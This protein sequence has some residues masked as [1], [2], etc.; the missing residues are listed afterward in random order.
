MR[1]ATTITNTTVPAD[2]TCT[3]AIAMTTNQG[4]QGHTHNQQRRK[5]QQQQQQPLRQ[6][7]TRAPAITATSLIC[8]SCSALHD[9]LRSAP[10]P[11]RSTAE[12]QGTRT[13]SRESRA[14]AGI[15]RN[16]SRGNGA[17]SIRHQ[18]ERG[19]PGSDVESACAA[20]GAAAGNLSVPP[21]SDDLVTVARALAPALEAF[22]VLLLSD[23]TSPVDMGRGGGEDEG[24]VARAG[25]DVLRLQVR[26]HFNPRPLCC[27]LIV[28]LP[29]GHALHTLAL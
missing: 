2:T 6:S 11:R 8:R 9:L 22:S 3:T 18:Q 24:D 15:L 27:L 23:T 4:R 14:G 25:S 28:S 17:G 16:G 21:S 19:Q 5:Q 13:G 12:L 7:F 10:I 29:H 20:G 1:R 26:V